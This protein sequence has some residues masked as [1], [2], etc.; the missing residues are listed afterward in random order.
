MSAQYAKHEKASFFCWYLVNKPVPEAGM[1]ADD[2][3]GRETAQK[4]DICPRSKASMAN[5]TLL[6]ET[7]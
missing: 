3:C 1:S 2:V 4:I 7:E 5:V 6:S